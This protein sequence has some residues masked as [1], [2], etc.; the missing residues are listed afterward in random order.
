MALPPWNL[1]HKKTVFSQYPRRPLLL[2][3]GFGAKLISPEKLSPCE[4][5]VFFPPDVRKQNLSCFT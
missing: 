4:T 1:L 5:R 3:V 2:E